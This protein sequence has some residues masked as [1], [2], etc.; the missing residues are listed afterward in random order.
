VAARGG[1]ALEQVEAI[2]AWLDERYRDEIDWEELRGVVDL[3][4]RHAMTV[5]RRICGMTVGQYLAQLRLAHAQR[6]LLT[7]DAPV[8]A[9][10]MDAGFGSLARFYVAFKRAFGRSPAAYRRSATTIGE[11]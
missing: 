5:F 4:P 9:I 1:S 8:L 6:G 10:A 2:A 3:H 7:S 11:G